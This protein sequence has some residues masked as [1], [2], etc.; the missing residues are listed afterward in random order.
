MKPDAKALY[1]PDNI[2]LIHNLMAVAIMGVVYIHF[3]DYGTHFGTTVSKLIIML[4]HPIAMSTISFCS[5]FYQGKGIRSGDGFV[6]VGRA[7]ALLIVGFVIFIPYCE[8]RGYLRS[9]TSF[10]EFLRSWNWLSSLLSLKGFGILWYVVALFVWRILAPIIVK[11]KY[12]LVLVFMLG[13]LS[14]C[15]DNMEST[16]YSMIL[17]FMPFYFLGVNTNWERIINIRISKVKYFSI[18]ALCVSAF[19]CVFFRFFLNLSPGVVVYYALRVSWIF[20][21]IAF[22]PGGKF[23]VFTKIGVNCMTLYFLHLYTVVLLSEFAI[24]PFLRYCDASALTVSLVQIAVF[25]FTVVVFSTD[26]PTRFIINATNFVYRNI[27]KS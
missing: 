20:V 6:S 21:L 22:F 27:F 1:S 2:F 11:I 17:R 5:G 26:Y 18:L 3:A 9:S 10:V 7:L 19:I 12:H 24:Y 4:L 15:S 14:C 16:W 8:V 25:F 23:P 13:I